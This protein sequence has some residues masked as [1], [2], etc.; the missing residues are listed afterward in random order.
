MFDKVKVL[1]SWKLSWGLSFL[2]FGVSDGHIF[3]DLLN[4]CPYVIC[5]KSESFLL[6]LGW[7]RFFLLKM[8]ALLL[9][10]VAKTEDLL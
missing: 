4:Y 10:L 8:E 3:F 6:Y 5:M 1:M 7:S 9:H 2:L